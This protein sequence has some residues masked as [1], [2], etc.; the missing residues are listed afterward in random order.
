MEFASSIDS[1]HNSMKSTTGRKKEK[2]EYLETKKY[3]TGM[4]VGQG[5]SQRRNKNIYLKTNDNE[6]TL[7]NLCDAAKA[8]LRGNF[9]VKQVFL[10]KNLLPKIPTKTTSERKT[11]KQKPKSAEGRK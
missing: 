1:D 10:K 9:I 11:N 6:N 3:F 8:V 7:K 4:P 2:K 5:W